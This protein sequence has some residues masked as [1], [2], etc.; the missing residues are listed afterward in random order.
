[1]SELTPSTSA[2]RAAS[3]LASFQFD[4]RKHLDGVEPFSPDAHC[5]LLNACR[6]RVVSHEQLGQLMQNG[7][8]PY[9]IDQHGDTVFSFLARCGRNET[10][11]FLYDYPRHRPPAAQYEEGEK[12]DGSSPLPML[13]DLTRNA[14]S[15]DLIRAAG[16]I[17]R[18]VLD[19]FHQLVELQPVSKAHRLSVHVL[20]ETLEGSN[21]AATLLRLSRLGVLSA[22]RGSIVGNAARSANIELLNYLHERRH[23]MQERDSLGRDALMIAANCGTA[24]RHGENDFLTLRLLLRMNLS[25]TACDRNG[26]TA[27]MHAAERGCLPAMEILY[28]AGSDFDKQDHEGRNIFD[29]YNPWNESSPAFF[30]NLQ[31]MKLHFTSL[32]GS[33]ANCATRR[34]N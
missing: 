16:G 21:S 11:K 17:C 30:R 34:T 23:D 7:A 4:W 9:A 31:Q 10:F 28:R 27:F 2:Q 24:N 12:V 32:E 20:L 6:D 15:P 26:F 22:T 33:E 29:I 3:E 5:T 1:M 25:V 14:I 19:K 13:L 8:D 18:D